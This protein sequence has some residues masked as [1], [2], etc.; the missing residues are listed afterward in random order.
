[1]AMGIFEFYKFC[2][3]KT[4]SIYVARKGTVTVYEIEGKTYLTNNMAASAVM[5]NPADDYW[6][7]AIDWAGGFS[8]YFT[9][10]MYPADNPRFKAD[11]IL[12]ITPA[13][14]EK[15]RIMVEAQKSRYAAA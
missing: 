11:P 5:E 10:G 9:T 12:E 6:C 4:G 13:Q 1:M 8:D 2:R 14:K 3:G 15:L 7:H